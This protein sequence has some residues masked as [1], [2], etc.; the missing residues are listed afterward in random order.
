MKKKIFCILNLSKLNMP[1]S[2]IIKIYCATDLLRYFIA[3]TGLTFL[4]LILF[5]RIDST[6]SWHHETQEHIK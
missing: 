1:F 5:P 6:S 2:E 3:K 4:Q